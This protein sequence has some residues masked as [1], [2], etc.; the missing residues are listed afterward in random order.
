MTVRPA[1]LSLGDDVELRGVIYRLTALDGDVVMLAVAGEAPVAI[2]VGSLLA[3][4]TFRIVGT[5]PTRRRITGP[6]ML[7]DSLPT[8]V[9]EKA[10]WMEGHM[11]EVLDGVPCNADPGQPA[12]RTFD[13]ARTSLRQR[14]QAK[15]A[16]L[17][18][19]GETMS[20][21]S[22]QRLRHAYE[23]EGVL[24]LVDR[25]LI[26]QT[27]LAGRTDQRVVDAILS[28]LE[29][30]THQSSGTTDRLMRQVG[31]QLEA[32]YGPDIV[33]LPSRATFH[34]LIGK[35]AEGRHATGSAR[36]RRT[37]AQQPEGPFGA[38]YPV[39]PG[40]LM[41][42]DST[43]LD[44]A[45]ELDDGV[46]GRVELTAMVDIATRSIPAAVV[47]PAT[48]AVDAAL[49][50][51]RC[52]TPELMRPG[53]A[54]AASMAASA[55]PYR[56]MK[57]ID[58]RLAG[59]AA[60]PVIVPETIVCDHG[61]A[62]LSNTFKSACRSQGISL[63]PARP[64]TPTDK[65]VIERTLQSIG[66]LFA[67]YVTGYLGSSVERRGK[68]AEHQ[69][70]FSLPEIQDLLDEWIVTGWQNRPHDGLRD[71]FTP[72]R[73]LTPNE[74][75]AAL[76]A[77]SGYVPVPFGAE[78]YLELMPAE[79]RV[80][81]SYG[82]KIRHR[83]YDTAELNPYRGQKSGMKALNGL[84]EVRYDPYDAGCVWIRNHHDGGWIT[85]YWRHLSA[86]PQP[87]GDDIWN[88]G[89][90]IVAGRGITS[91]SEDEIKTAVDNIL[92]KASPPAKPRKR[93]RKDQRAAARNAAAISAQRPR[94]YLD[95][96]SPQPD[97]VGEPPEEQEMDATKLAKIIPLKVYDPHKEAETWW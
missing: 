13:V 78:D 6:S 12:K 79:T 11:T 57:S 45:V 37:L 52:L 69:A 59:S 25:R 60:K 23:K 24:G 46:I 49:L 8:D 50:L 9:Q 89:R 64:D 55:L 72:S 87:F 71:P 58:E 91:P 17:Q 27:P 5:R 15:L 56:S 86:S 21:G 30:N 32:A 65:P 81:N 44:I 75:Y 67:Q 20:I 54:Q 70:V 97:P 40:E 51:A 94:P 77:V 31:K 33:P 53:W 82:V 93:N 19:L 61:K 62:Y 41:Q 74:K 39:R 16:E 73:V 83:V 85:A 47:R 90:Q 18:D 48:K 35:L 38:V 42:I 43:A 22:L 34:R 66:T 76:L 80:I 10:R 14:E 63:Q 36:T 1:V 29:A 92:D 28:V 7:F 95:Q 96:Q 84:W 26:R 2:K 4:E 88:Y 68:N 3:D